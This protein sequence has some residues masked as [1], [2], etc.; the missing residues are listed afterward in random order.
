MNV[1]VVGGKL[2]GL[3]ASYLAKKAGWQVALIDRLDTVPALYVADRH[4]CVEIMDKVALKRALKGTNLIIPAFENM[5]ALESLVE[6]ASGMDI[7]C[8]F[9]ISAY[10]ISSSKMVS[11]QL[12]RRIGIPSPRYYPDCPFPLVAKPSGGSG[13]EGVVLIK[14][15]E[16]LSQFSRSQRSGLGEW[17]VQEY[18]P[19]P[20]F[21]QEVIGFQGAFQALQITDLEM[22]A[23][24]DCKR[25][26]APTVLDENLQH[27]FTDITCQIAA[28]LNL[29]GVMDVEVVLSAGKLYV[30]EIDARLPSQT[31]SVVYHSSG[32]N[33]VALAGEALSNNRA[34]LQPKTGSCKHA[35]LEHLAVSPGVVSVSGEHVIAEAG[36][37][38]HVSGFFG[39]DEAL[40][41][42]S[43]GKKNWVATLINSASERAE[44]DRKRRESLEQICSQ[45][46][47][48][49]VEG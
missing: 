44:L 18:L 6:T 3:E 24:Y 39:S 38:N 28:E 40:T 10:S 17:V 8:L 34:P 1:A 4:F 22:D 29:N 31:P 20:T 36:P 32:Q 12:F 7:P 13:S 43:P 48:V 19:G 49:L 41:D 11:D 45:A 15:R 37:L 21:S 46:G 30:L 5:Q 2:Q 47:A 27:I 35:V 25:V 42:Y 14:D 26:S 23:G 9:D 16:E 33:L